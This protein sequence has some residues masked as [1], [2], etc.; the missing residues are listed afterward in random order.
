MTKVNANRPRINA[1]DKV[2]RD[3]PK[4]PKLVFDA[5]WDVHQAPP[6]TKVGLTAVALAQIE[7]EGHTALIK[8]F[9]I[10][11]GE[12]V[13]IGPVFTAPFENGQVKTEWT[14]VAA[15]GN[16][17][18]AGE[19]HY[20]VWVGSNFGRTTKGLLLRDVPVNHNVSKF[21]T[22][23]PPLIKGIF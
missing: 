20:E 15:K 18:K 3:D 10:L 9:Q 12:R 7:G 21:E 8:V 23:K 11:K 4:I 19:Y 5:K 2:R 17:Y 16:D 13:P 1:P 22:V 6:G 14:T